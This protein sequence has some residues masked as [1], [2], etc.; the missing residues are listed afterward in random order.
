M[1]NIL[2]VI[3]LVFFSILAVILIVKV[4]PKTS[5]VLSIISIIAV[6]CVVIFLIRYLVVNHA[7]GYLGSPADS[8]EITEMEIPDSISPEKLENCI[9]IS[10]DQIWIDNEIVDIEFAKT[11]V[12][13]RIASNTTITIVDDY[14]LASK[15]NEILE[16][17]KNA[18]IK[19]VK[20][21]EW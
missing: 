18:N 10:Y 4:F 13:N 8:G 3:L 20:Y 21:E 6:L 11:Y 14:A 12:N 15:Y 7:F 17:C 2:A 5:K 19:P 9:R 1:N 16:I